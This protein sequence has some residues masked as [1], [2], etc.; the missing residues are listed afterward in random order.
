MIVRRIA[1][2]MLSSIFILG[3]IG[4]VR[5]AAA[6]KAAAE[7]IVKAIAG[8]LGLPQDTELLVRADGAAMVA[9]GVL[10]ATGRFP[11]LASSLLIGSFVPVTATHQFWKET[12]PQKK[13]QERIH[14]VKNVS[15]LGGLL[16]AAADTAGKPGL[17]YRAKLAGDSVGR[18]ARSARQEE[19]IAALQAKSA[20]S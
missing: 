15:L 4:A 8:P 14:F 10:L 19:K 11:R 20:V 18:T 9:G 3:G 1:R 16:I 17:A 13:Q 12:D 7:P 5:N 6:H 2:P